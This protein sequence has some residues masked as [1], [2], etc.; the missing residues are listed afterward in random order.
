M[1][2]NIDL[3]LGNLWE[4]LS[5]VGTIA[6]VIVS[7]WLAKRESKIRVK[8]HVEGFDQPLNITT[9]SLEKFTTIISFKFYNLSNYQIS[10]TSIRAIFL[11][12]P[13]CFLIRYFYPKMLKKK[14]KIN[15]QIFLNEPTLG[16]YSYLPLEIES[17]SNNTFFFLLDKFINS[18]P[19][20]N[21]QY[22]LF[23]AKASMG[24]EYYFY[25]EIEPE[26]IKLYLH[27]KNPQNQDNDYNN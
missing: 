17:K 8:F 12:K 9:G 13:V 11:K 14:T 22:I 4:M 19:N 24:N 7:L 27:K 16:P 21:K 1:N 20:D 25:Q 6:A 3:D 18:L 23:V 5:S 2:I 15:E 10:I 26:K